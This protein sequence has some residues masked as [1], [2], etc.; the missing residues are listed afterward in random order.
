[1]TLGDCQVTLTLEIYLLSIWD[2]W[3]II[4]FIIPIVR[5]K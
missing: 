3:D 4:F 1:M 2:E 5:V